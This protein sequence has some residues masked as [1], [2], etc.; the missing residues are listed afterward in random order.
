VPLQA[1]QNTKIITH[2]QKH[3]CSSAT[4][5]AALNA[6][7]IRSMFQLP[8]G[9]FI[10]PFGVDS[11]FT[12]TVKFQSKDTLRRHFKMSGLKVCDS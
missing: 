12:D 5:I 1:E 2:Y 7:L 10:P 4:G 3:G 6:C 9:G 11:Q 8:F